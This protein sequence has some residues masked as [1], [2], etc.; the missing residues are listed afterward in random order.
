MPKSDADDAQKGCGPCPKG[1]VEH[2]PQDAR[3][4]V[5]ARSAPAFAVDAGEAREGEVHGLALQQGAERLEVAVAAAGVAE[6]ADG[7]VDQV[8]V[9]LVGADEG[10][11]AKP[12]PVQNVWK[13]NLTM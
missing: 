2:F 5:G 6:V 1:L 9:D 12:F 10:L 4:L 11:K 8:E 3:Q 13:S 7:A